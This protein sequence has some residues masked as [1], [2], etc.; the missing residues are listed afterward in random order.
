LE[1][2]IERAELVAELNPMLANAALASAHASG[3]LTSIGSVVSLPGFEPGFSPKQRLLRDQVMTVL[4]EAGLSPPSVPELTANLRSNEVRPVLRLLE[5]EGAVTAVSFD[6]YLDAR[7][8]ARAI[9]AVRADPNDHPRT[10]ADFKTALPVSRKY[11]IPLL[12]YLDR[13]GVTRREGDLRWVVGGEPQKLH[14]L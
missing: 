13:S 6:L 8:L 1:R 14:E 5:A 10:A 4:Q 12:E 9:Q 7:I 3:A 2:G 11:L